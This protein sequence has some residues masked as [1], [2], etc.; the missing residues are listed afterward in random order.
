MKLLSTSLNRR[1]T[2]A[3]RFIST[4]LVSCMFIFGVVAVTEAQQSEKPSEY[5][6]P[7]YKIEELTPPIAEKVVV[8]RVRRSLRGTEV[9]ML[10][11]I[12]ETG[13]P[14]SISDTAGARISQKELAIAMRS[15]LKRWEFEPARNPQG[16]AVAVKVRLP[17]KVVRK[18]E[19]NAKEYASFA[20]G[21]PVIV[22]IAE[23]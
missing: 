6:L 3:W 7:L 10:F 19:G 8:P 2:S 16:Q 21:T 20:L 1:Y 22:A 17:V 12:S 23:F 18:G 15:S 4:T 5:T 14:Q 11:R 9:D 13:K